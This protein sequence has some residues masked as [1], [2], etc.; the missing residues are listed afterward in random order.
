MRYQFDAVKGN[1]ARGSFFTT[2]L[3]F[4][5]LGQ[6]TTI[7]PEVQR[8]AK[9][10][11]IKKLFEYIV[12]TDGYYLP[13]ITLAAPGNLTFD[14]KK[15]ILTLDDTQKLSITDGQHRVLAILQLLE[16][17]LRD[18]YGDH[19]IPCTIFH[20]MQVDRQLDLFSVL[21][22]EQ[23]PVTKAEREFKNYRNRAN[24][25]TH[26]VVR[27]LNLQEVCEYR[28]SSIKNKPGKWFAWTWLLEA[29]RWLLHP[30]TATDEANAVARVVEFWR[31]VFKVLGPYF[32][33]PEE[34]ICSSATA[35]YGI[36][37]VGRKIITAED[38]EQ[39]VFGLASLNWSRDP[40]TSSFEGT[41]IYNGQ[42]MRSATTSGGVSLEVQAI[43]R[44][45]FGLEE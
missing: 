37:Q 18:L 42:W 36:G 5:V 31:Y 3:P 19:K 16:T 38:M 11:K 23:T 30:L 41:M 6:I 39:R 34:F 21:N 7:N 4:H 10:R 32:G 8:R 44:R 1:Q 27:L 28:T 24:R 35:V 22:G 13:S 40:A 14:D 15:K 2:A 29:N 12:N 45:A 20:R 43:L 26:D 25:V 33:K 9:P 17:E